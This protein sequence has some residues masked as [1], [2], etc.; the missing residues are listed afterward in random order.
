MRNKHIYIYIYT[1][2]IHHLYS[3]RSAKILGI[4]LDTEAANPWIPCPVAGALGQPPPMP[5]AAWHVASHIH[6]LLVINHISIAVLV[7][8][9]I[10][11]QYQYNH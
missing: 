7:G 8:I 3:R 4:N 5:A 10:L 6:T 11:L 2:Y 1:I 9:S